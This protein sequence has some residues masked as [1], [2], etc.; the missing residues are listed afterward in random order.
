MSPAGFEI[1]RRFLIRPPS[2]AY[3]DGLGAGDHYRQGYVRNGKPSVRIRMGEPRGPVLTLKKGKGVKRREVET[4]VPQDVAEALLEAAEDRV[5]EKVRF[6]VGPWD[7]DRFLGR[8][9]GLALMEVEL[10]DEDDP[11]PEPPDGIHVIREVTD[12]KRFVSGHLARMGSKKARKLVKKAY[13][14]AEA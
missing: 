12:D 11:L 1:E 13:A 5:I 10:E 6:R 4:V 9:R 2:D 7:V 14:E 8:F 3:W